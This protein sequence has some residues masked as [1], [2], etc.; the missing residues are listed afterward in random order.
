MN[1]AM[2]FPYWYISRKLNSKKMK[3][4][5]QSRVY[6]LSFIVNFRTG[7]GPVLSLFGLKD[8]R[9]GPS[10][11]A[12]TVDTLAFTLCRLAVALLLPA[13]LS[14]VPAEILKSG[15]IPRQRR[16]AMM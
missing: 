7:P 8:R 6:P 4:P 1:S 9:T 3:F 11:K 10:K 5:N 12:S 15:R 2:F 14:L 13:N 16:V